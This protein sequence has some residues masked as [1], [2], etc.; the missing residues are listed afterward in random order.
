MLWR[1]QKDNCK[2]FRL[3]PCRLP[4]DLTDFAAWMNS[5]RRLLCFLGAMY[6][7]LW[8]PALKKQGQEAD[9]RLFHHNHH[10]IFEAGGLY[11]TELSGDAGYNLIS[12][13][14]KSL[15]CNQPET[16]AKAYWAFCIY[17]ESAWRKRNR[18]CFTYGGTVIKRTGQLSEWVGRWVFCILY[19]MAEHKDIQSGRWKAAWHEQEV[20]QFENKTEIQFV[21]ITRHLNACR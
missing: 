18:I 16:S 13:A 17:D 7:S 11:L 15:C 20:F 5:F 2:N 21:S 8:L 3:F 12:S 19:I 4:P 6:C 1:F 14:G 10:C 9:I